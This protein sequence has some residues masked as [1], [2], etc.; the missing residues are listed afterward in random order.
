MADET[1]AIPT[2]AVARTWVATAP[3]AIQPYLRLARL[4]RPI[5]T[6]LLYWPCVFGLA[7]GAAEHQRGFLQ[8]APDWGL[9]VLFAL[10]A[11]FMR[12][13]GCTYNDIVDRDIDMKVART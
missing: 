12:G 1:Q 5:G 2:D 4:D 10:G 8:A 9:L 3:L 13:A 6:W 7:V 11:V